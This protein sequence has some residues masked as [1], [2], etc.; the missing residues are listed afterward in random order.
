[1]FLESRPAD[2]LHLR[3]M[4]FPTLAG[5]LALVCSQMRSGPLILLPV[6]YE[7]V[8]IALIQQEHMPT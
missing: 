3:R 8:L 6:T 7:K 5:H 4:A 1:M 2:L